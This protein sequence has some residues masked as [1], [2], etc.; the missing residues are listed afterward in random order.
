M[1]AAWKIVAWALGLWAAAQLAGWVFARNATAVVAVQAALAEW[2]AGRVGIAWSDPL[3]PLPTWGAVGGRAGRG[4]ALGAVAAVLVVGLGLTTHA[5]AMAAASPALAPIAVGLV[6]VALTA[7]RDELL[8]RGFV[9]R[10]VRDLLP[11]WGALV[12]CGAAAAAARFGAD[13]VA[14]LAMAVEALRGAALGAIWLRDRGTW[15]AWGANAAWMWTLGSLA[16]G[17]LIDVRFAV[18]PSAGV[19]TLAVL[20]VGCGAAALWAL[21]RPPARD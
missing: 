2:G 1:K 9:L 10:A 8:L 5:A 11:A 12:V 4:A 7:V 6:V 21:R 20:A 17:G 18:D 3:A 19:P 16:R 15:M 13:G 14:T